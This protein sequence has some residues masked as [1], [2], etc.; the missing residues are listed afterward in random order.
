MK[1]VISYSFCKSLSWYI[2]NKEKGTEIIKGENKEDVSE[3]KD[4]NKEESSEAKEEEKIEEVS[5]GKGKVKSD[6]DI[7]P[8]DADILDSMCK[9][10][11]S[12]DTSDRIRTRAM[13]CNI[14]HHAL[15]NRWFEA[16]NLMLMS[17]LQETVQH[18]D[19]PTQ[20]TTSGHHSFAWL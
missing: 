14:Y 7:G 2:G 16:R 15:H 17:H 6:T 20:V 19:I 18:S 3:G 11:Y 12:K 10:I 5:E 9:Y 4:E 8:S 1:N 13:L